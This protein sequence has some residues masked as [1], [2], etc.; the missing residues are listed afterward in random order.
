MF[1][2]NFAK[3]A[4]TL[5]VPMSALMAAT[6]ATAGVSWSFGI[7]VPAPAVL[8]PAPI[9]YE[10]APTYVVPAPSYYP[11]PVLLRPAPQVYYRPTPPVYQPP[12]TS[13]RVEHNSYHSNHYH[14]HDWNDDD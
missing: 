12:V 10:P 9:Y 8:A 5:I 13:L 11:P 7:N 2:N 6:S 4:I 3:R 14:Y 1:L